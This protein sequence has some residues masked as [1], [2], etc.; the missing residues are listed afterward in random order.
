M[1]KEQKEALEHELRKLKRD[2][3][4]IKEA[5]NDKGAGVIIVFIILFVVAYCLL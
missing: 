1:S 5:A 3:W 2:H 4:R